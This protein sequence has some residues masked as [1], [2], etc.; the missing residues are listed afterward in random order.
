VIV[1]RDADEEDRAASLSWKRDFVD[2]IPLPA[3]TLA[4]EPQFISQLDGFS[5]SDRPG[6]LGFG[7]IAGNK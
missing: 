3:W 5:N 7:G 4:V 2:P 6:P 1:A